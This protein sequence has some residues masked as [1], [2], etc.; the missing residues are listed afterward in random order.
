M[1]QLLSVFY[2][3]STIIGLLVIVLV[4]NSKF[5]IIVTGELL[6]AILVRNE[7]INKAYEILVY[8]VYPLFVFIV[9]ALFYYLVLKGAKK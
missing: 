7:V 4:G 2:I 9:S 5:A 3:L 8:C 6:L 1:E